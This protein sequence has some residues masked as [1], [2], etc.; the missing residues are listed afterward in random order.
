MVTIEQTQQQLRDQ[1]ISLDKT[2]QQVQSF[3]PQPT[4]PQSV[5]RQKFNPLQP[6]RNSPLLRRE[7]L[8]QAITKRKLAKAT[9]LTKLGE[10]EVLQSQQEQSFQD[11]LKTDSGK[12]LFFR[13]CA[14]LVKAFSSAPVIKRKATSTFVLGNVSKKVLFDKSVTPFSSKSLS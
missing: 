1:S 13:F 11:Y 4:I 7:Q 3:Q 6:S 8:R 14:N 2:K 5:L 12:L 9:A 10:A